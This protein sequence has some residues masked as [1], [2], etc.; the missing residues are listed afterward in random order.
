[1]S[2]FCQTILCAGCQSTPLLLAKESMSSQILKV[3]KCFNC[4]FNDALKTNV[5]QMPVI[6]LTEE[7]EAR[8]SNRK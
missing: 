2:I 6:L 4:G 5:S 7:H 8:H 3:F 1:M